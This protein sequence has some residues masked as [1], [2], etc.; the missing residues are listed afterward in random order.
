MACDTPAARKVSGFVNLNAHRGYLKCLKSFTYVAD[1]NKPNYGG[2]D[3]ENWS[4]RE[5]SLVQSFAD[6]WH[7]ATSQQAQRKIQQEYGIKY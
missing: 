6:K 2:F 3:T 1:I 5:L 7:L 4:K